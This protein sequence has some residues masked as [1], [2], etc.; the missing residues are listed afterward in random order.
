MRCD[1]AR[2][3]PLRKLRGPQKSPASP[4]GKVPARRHYLHAFGPWAEG[5]TISRFMI[6]LE[7][8]GDHMRRRVRA[9][10]LSCLAL[11][12]ILKMQS[13]SVSLL[14][15]SFS[16]SNHGQRFPPP[17]FLCRPV[18]YGPLILQSLV[19]RGHCLL[20]LRHIMKRVDIGLFNGSIVSLFGIVDQ[21]INSSEML[22][23][24]IYHPFYIGDLRHIGINGNR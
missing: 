12:S 14:Y 5:A 23:R 18:S 8:R 1:C 7:T 3:R 2:R 15:C 16:S 24:L 6:L 19:E 22:L 21:D 17:R 10:R 4:A 13:C 9:G 20:A 11:S